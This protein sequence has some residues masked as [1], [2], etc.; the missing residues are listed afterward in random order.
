MSTVRAA[1]AAAMAG[2]A[3]I[4]RA[5]SVRGLSARIPSAR[6]PASSAVRRGR[7]RAQNVP[8]ASG[9][10]ASVRAAIARKAIGRRAPLVS[11]PH[12]GPRGLAASVPPVTG[13]AMSG[14]RRASAVH[15]QRL[16]TAVIAAAG[17][18][19]AVPFASASA[20]P[21][22][23]KIRGQP[24]Q[25]VSTPPAG[26]SRAPATIAAARPVVRAG[27]A[28]VAVLPASAATGDPTTAAPVAERRWVTGK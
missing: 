22:P 27:I 4:V 1:T 8:A 24:A 18:M 9:P 20:A 28:S 11:T 15:A 19:S 7:T 21:M 25:M 2:G 10:V 13:I 5:R 16:A 26:P 3:E 6:A 17:R 14:A 12:A 23:D